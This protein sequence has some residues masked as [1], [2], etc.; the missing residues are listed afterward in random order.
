MKMLRNSEP[1]VVELNIDC[2]DK[3]V[4][5]YTLNHKRTKAKLLKGAN[6]KK[7]LEIEIKPGCVNLHFNDGSYHEIL[8][9]QLRE[10]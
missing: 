8:L 4:F 7:N 3:R 2:D 10:W 1:S 9:P 6:E 5:D